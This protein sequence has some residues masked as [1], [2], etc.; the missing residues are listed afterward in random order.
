MTQPYW[1]V[2]LALVAVPACAQQSSPPS[3]G[4]SNLKVDMVS[5][6]GGIRISNIIG[7]AVYND[8]NEKIGSIDDLMTKSD[9]TIVEAII[10]VGGFLGIGSKLVAIPYEQ[11]NVDMS[12]KQSQHVTLAGASK[13]KLAAM[14]PFTYR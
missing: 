6:A 1:L 8:H 10:S 14:T 9:R 3:V 2:V 7:S 5:M 11:L 13:D 12:E 4:D